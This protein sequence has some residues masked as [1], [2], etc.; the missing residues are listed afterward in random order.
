MRLPILLVSVL[1]LT[2]C[3]TTGPK[4]VILE[5]PEKPGSKALLKE[6]VI[7]DDTVAQ[8]NIQISQ[9]DLMIMKTVTERAG[10][11]AN[12]SKTGEIHADAFWD[13]MM[14]STKT[15]LESLM[16]KR[17]SLARDATILNEFIYTECSSAR[18]TREMV[19][20]VCENGDIA[21][22]RWCLTK[23]F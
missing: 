7:N 16:S 9:V 23:F 18:F 14:I 17:L 22:K 11:D 19:K 12:S 3:A 20:D 8:L 4:V 6:C 10:I 5:L 15:D 21:Q 1:F 13:A 2:S